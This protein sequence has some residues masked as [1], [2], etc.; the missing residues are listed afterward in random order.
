[1]TTEERNA[2]HREWWRNRTAE[3]KAARVAQNRQYRRSLPAEERAKLVSYNRERISNFTPE[4]KEEFNRKQR[5]RERNL[6]SESREKFKRIRAEYKATNETYKAKSAEYSKIWRQSHPD[7]L[8]TYRHKR[9]SMLAGAEG[10]YTPGEWRDLVI[11][12]EHRCVH[13]RRQ[14]PEIKLTVDHIIPV[15]KGGSNWISNIQPL[16]NSCNSKKRDKVM[17]LIGKAA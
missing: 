7:E 11:R 8:R 4:Q 1:M 2:Y 13:C 17:T 15:S 14:E 16:C 9:R 12:C 6:P 3:Q 5:E 10:S